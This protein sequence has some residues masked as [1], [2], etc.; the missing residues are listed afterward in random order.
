MTVAIG[1]KRLGLTLLAAIAAG[2]GALAAASLLISAEGAS[3]ALKTEIRTVTG[4]APTIRGSVSVSTFPLPAIR[5]AN[6]LIGDDHEPVIAADHLTAHL[7]LLPLLLGRLEVSRIALE[8]PR[9]AIHIAADGRSNWSPLLA[10]LARS[11]DPS[12]IREPVALFS[13]IQIVN[14][15]ITIRDEIHKLTET[16]TDADLWLEWPT[17]SKRV[18]A[19]GRFVWRNEPVE[20]NITFGDSFAALAGNISSLKVRLT[21]APMKIAFDGAISDRPS[22]KVEGNLAVDAPSLR[23]ALRWTGGKPLSGGGFGRFSLAAKTNLVGE[24]I[25]LSGVHLELDGNTAEGVLSYAMNERQI[26]QGTLAAEDLDVTPYISTI[27]LV[28]T[29]ARDWDRMPITLDGLTGFDI[30]L[31]LSAARVTIGNAKLGRTAVAATLRGGRLALTVGE[32]QA[33]NGVITGSIAIAKSDAGAELKSQ[34]QFA[35]VELESCLGALF[36]FRRIEGKGH[37][38][39]DIAG[40]GPNVLALT[41]TLHGTANITARKG[42]LAGLN[43]EQLLRRLERRPLSIP[44]EF[45]G[46]RTSYDKL[47]IALH[48]SQGVATIDE[49]ALESSAVRV[50]LSGSATIPNHEIDFKGS[51][52]LVTP[53]NEAPFE[54]PFVVQGSWNDPIILPDPQI[55]IRRS[56]AAAPLLDAVRDKRSRDAVRSAIERLTGPTAR[57]TD[58]ATLAEPMNR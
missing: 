56:G 45:R 43:V 42:A 21:G 24:S 9:I 30:D 8:N 25:A 28:A 57:P 27:R 40:S 11:L 37:L 19:T 1:F 14:G 22:L 36:G 41:H 23:E 3:D 46:G 53:A 10:A 47:N 50:G 51:A 31:R 49:V 32:S 5:A 52:N 39:L 2:F 54:L 29:N 4:L 35:D 33:F 58:P 12:G 6:I 16:L 17:M 13:D 44:G 20:T 26:W 55:L 7:R 15:T 18:D 38:S 34:M 48:I